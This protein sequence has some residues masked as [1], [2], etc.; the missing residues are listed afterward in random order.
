MAKKVNVPIVSITLSQ[1]C[2]PRV[3]CSSPFTMALSWQWAADTAQ[4]CGR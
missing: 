4:L 3:R 1:L 2:D